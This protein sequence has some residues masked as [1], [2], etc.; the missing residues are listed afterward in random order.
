M[1]VEPRS[2]IAAPPVVAGDAALGTEAPDAR[3]FYGYWL[4]GAAFVAQFVSVGSQNYVVGAFLKPMTTDLG[5]TRSEFT[6]ART[7]G[8]FVMAFTGFFI[9]AYVDR[10][11]GRRLMSVGI[12]ILSAALYGLSFTRELWQWIALN[13]IVLTAGAALIGGLVVNVT[14]SK[15]FVARRGLAIGL[16]SMGVSFAGVLLTPVMT[17]AIDDYG[18]RA[19]WRIMGVSAFAL[20]VPVTFLMRKGPEHYGLRP[21]GVSALQ[22]A[23]GAGARA[24][25]DFATSLTRQEAMRTSAFYMLVLAFGMFGVTI[26]VML[27]QTIPF[28]TDAGYSRATASGMITVTSIP[29]LISKPFWGTLIDRLNPQ[30]LAC[31]STVVT[32]IAMVVITLSVRSTTDPLVYAGFALLGFGWGGLIPLQE[33]IWATFFGRRYLGA[34]RSAG[35][36]FSL[37]LGAGAPLIV[38]IYFDRVGNYD[39]ALLVIAAL[40]IVA[41]VLILSIRKPRR[42]DA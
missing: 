23:A 21:D 39:G 3:F 22:A 29:A 7:L 20:I 42:A 41:A 19:A 37:I 38:S 1:G 31:I 27:L 26:G 5:W 30:R 35:L 12:V 8:Q 6:L 33:V 34:V 24:T 2:A 11:G 25:A 9:G 13:G 10:Q 17:W 28:M 14:L 4:I 18:W 36:P 40:N 15:W 32:G 16:S